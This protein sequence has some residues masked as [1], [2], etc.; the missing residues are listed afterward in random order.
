M[1]TTPHSPP[2]IGD[3][4][5]ELGSKSESVTKS[6]WALADHLNENSDHIVSVNVYNAKECSALASSFWIAYE[7]VLV[8]GTAYTV[9]HQHKLELLDYKAQS[10]SCC[11]EERR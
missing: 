10:T 2:P 3:P 9:T 5:D 6:L 1:L 4:G 11:D 7:S 8:V